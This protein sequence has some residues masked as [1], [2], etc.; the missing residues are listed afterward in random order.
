M[1][2]RTRVCGTKANYGNGSLDMRPQH[3]GGGTSSV[4]MFLPEC[5]CFRTL[6][7][8]P[9]VEETEHVCEAFLATRTSIACHVKY[10]RGLKNYHYHGAILLM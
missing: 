5:L 8:E 9:G 2:L 10:C 4:T 1:E 3:L 7:L 6:H